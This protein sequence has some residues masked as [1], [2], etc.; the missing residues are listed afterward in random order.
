[1]VPTNPQGIPITGPILSW[2]I[3]LAFLTD[4]IT[5]PLNI[6]RQQRLYDIITTQFT[7]SPARNALYNLRKSNADTYKDYLLMKAQDQAYPLRAT[8]R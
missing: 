8:S 6:G 4:V 1:M 5:Y 7:N 2:P 3:F